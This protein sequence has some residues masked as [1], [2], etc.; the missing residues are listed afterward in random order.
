MGQTFKW[1]EEKASANLK[2]HRASF[3]EAASIFDDPMAIT[4]PDPLHSESEERC[5]TIG[6]SYK[7]RILIVAHTGRENKIRIINCRKATA[8]ERS[9]YEEN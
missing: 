5:L 3:N 2:K 7:G 9:L 6:I 1:D 8:L 4:F